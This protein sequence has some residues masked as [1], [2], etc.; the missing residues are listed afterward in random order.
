MPTTATPKHTTNDFVILD[1]LE[2]KYSQ[3]MKTKDLAR[4]EE[5]IAS[6]EARSREKWDE[7][8]N[9]WNGAGS[10]SGWRT[11]ARSGSRH[12]RTVA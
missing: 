11:A 9:R 3:G 7:T 2:F 1:D 6:H 5:L 4:A 8:F 12:P 10:A